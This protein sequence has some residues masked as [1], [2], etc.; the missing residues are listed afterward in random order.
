MSLIAVES[1]LPRLDA[2][3]AALGGEAIPRVEWDSAAEYA[4]TS[5]GLSHWSAEWRTLLVQGGRSD[6]L[7]P[8]DVLGALSGSG[9]GLSG[10][11]V[12]AIEVTEKRTWVAVKSASAADAAAALDRAKIKKG[13]FRVHL[14][15]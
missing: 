4:A 11:D 8:G 7:R 3:D 12:G 15:E 2:V 1:E 5:G 6:K 14:I 10:S 13:R 9:V